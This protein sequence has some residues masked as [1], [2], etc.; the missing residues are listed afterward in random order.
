DA[1]L[2]KILYELRDFRWDNKEQITDIKLELS[3]VNK[4]LD[5]AEGRTEEVET[6]V[7]RTETVIKKLLQRQVTLETKLTDQ[8]G[9]LRRENIRIYGIPEESEGCCMV[10]FLENL[11]RGEL[12]LPKDMELGIERAHRGVAKFLSYKMKEEVLGKAWQMKQTILCYHD[13][14]PTVLKK[15]MEYSEV[16]KVLKSQKIKFQTFPARLQV[17]YEDSTCLYHSAAEATKDMVEGG[18][19]VQVIPPAPTLEEEIERLF[20]WQKAG[21]RGGLR[22]D[23]SSKQQYKEKLQSFRRRPPSKD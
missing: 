5:K 13:N 12:D 21:R 23:Q 11:R 17:F 4:R 15:R 7:L 6:R 14:T 18:L 22:K 9:R 8:E 2:Q 19:K 3:N 20:T 1:S 16:K 10:T